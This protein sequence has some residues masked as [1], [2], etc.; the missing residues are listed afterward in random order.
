MNRAAPWYA[1]ASAALFGLST[2]FAKTLIG[3]IDP[4]FLAGL[5]YLGSGLGLGAVRVAYVR[6]SSRA[7]T[8]LGRADAPWL[9]GAI[10]FGGVAGPVLLMAG[11]LRTDGATA[12]LLLT[13]ESVATALIAWLVYREN[14]GRRIALGMGLIVAGAAILSWPDDASLGDA[15]G[16]LCVLGACLAWGIDNNLTRRVS[17]ADP[18]QI[19]LL[20]GLVAGP[21]NLVL[22]IVAGAHLPAI[23]VVPA[24]LVVGFLGYGVSLTLFVLALRHLGTART[25]AY[26]ATAPFLGAAAAIPVLGETITVPLIAAGAV[27]ALGVWLHLTERHEHEHEHGRLTHGH[28]HRHD[29]HHAHAHDKGDPAGEPHAHVHVHGPMRHSH[30]HVPD[31]H[32]RHRHR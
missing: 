30:P 29:S 2:P 26:Y 4:W 6:G 14:V 18:V 31:S 1:L 15:I 9:I 32:H 8:P 5:L 22:A 7:E 12:S 17:L 11:L 21:I 28:R 3:P 23:D 27:M 19:A 25:G 16:P 13:L 24:A 20:K 10:A